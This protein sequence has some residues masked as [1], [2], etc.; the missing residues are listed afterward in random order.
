[1]IICDLSPKLASSPSKTKMEKHPKNNDN[2]I[3]ELDHSDNKA[4]S[5]LAVFDFSEPNIVRPLNGYT[6]SSKNINFTLVGT[7]F[8]Q[9]AYSSFKI[10]Q[11]VVDACAYCAF[12]DKTIT[13]AELELLRAVSLTLHCPLPPLVADKQVS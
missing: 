4:T 12:A 10:K 11:S 13:I 9:L 1:L 3:E 8:K 2:H 6:T 7:A 5:S